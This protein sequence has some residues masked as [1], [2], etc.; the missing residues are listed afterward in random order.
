MGLTQ[1]LQTDREF[2]G[3]TVSTMRVIFSL[4]FLRRAE[5]LFGFL[6]C[7]TSGLFGPCSVH[8]DLEN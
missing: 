2:S 4:H 1:L 8:P 7:D 3:C 5:C 6:L